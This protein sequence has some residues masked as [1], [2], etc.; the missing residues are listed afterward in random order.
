MLLKCKKCKHE[1]NYKGD[2]R[3]YVTCPYCY[4]KVRINITEVKGGKEKDG[5]KT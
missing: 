3:Y 5:T 4:N 2:S 1:W